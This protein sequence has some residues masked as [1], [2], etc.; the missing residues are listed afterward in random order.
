MRDVQNKFRV[1]ECALDMEQRSNDAAA[2]DAQI[3]L[4]KVEC[5]LGMAQ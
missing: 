3:K 1:E 2:K 4:R 5:A